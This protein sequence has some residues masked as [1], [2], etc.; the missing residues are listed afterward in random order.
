[1]RLQSIAIDHI[2][3]AIEQ[4]GNVVLKPDVIE[5]SNMSLGINID[6]DVEIAI[7]PA[8]A[9]RNRA[10]NSGVTDS[11]RAQ[12]VLVAS[13]NGNA[14]RSVHAENISQNIPAGR[15]VGRFRPQKGIRANLEPQELRSNGRTAKIGTTYM[16]DCPASRAL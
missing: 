1:M 11:T 15:R 10:E 2:N 5:E 13:Q 7:Q 4:T 6:D 16:L 8:I 12:G 9:T 14:V 3:R